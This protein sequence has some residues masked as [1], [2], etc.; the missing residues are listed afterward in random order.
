MDLFTFFKSVLGMVEVPVEAKRG[1]GRP[2]K[3]SKEEAKARAVEAA[4]RCYT[5][6]AKLAQELGVP[7]YRVT[8]IKQ[9]K[10]RL[11]LAKCEQV[12]RESA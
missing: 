2:K 3:Y 1:R 8:S 10:E 12:L 7:Q 5:K 11:G 4:R 6:K 9:A